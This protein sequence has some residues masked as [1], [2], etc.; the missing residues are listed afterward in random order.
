MKL[1]KTVLMF[2]SLITLFVTSNIHASGWDLSATIGDVLNENAS[3][4]TLGVRWGFWSGS[5]FTQATGAINAGYLAIAGGEFSTSLSAISN[6]GDLATTGQQLYL[7]IYYAN[8]AGDSSNA[9]W[10]SAFTNY[11]ILSDPTWVVPTFALDPTLTGLSFS[12]NTVALVGSISGPSS[13]GASTI[14]LSS[15]AVPEP[16]TYALL[17]L[18]ALGLFL[19]FRGRKVQA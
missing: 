16:S 17:A 9:S 15:G 6:T 10:S 14:T 18:G 3:A 4:T 5:S 13:A 7:S 19:S 11:A 12:S 2:L 1:K 8:T